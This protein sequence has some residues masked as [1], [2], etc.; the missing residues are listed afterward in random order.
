MT[1]IRRV[2][3]SISG[4]YKELYPQ[5]EELLERPI[6]ATF[7][8]AGSSSIEEGITCLSEILYNQDQ[9]SPRMWKFFFTIIDLYVNDKGLL[10]EFIF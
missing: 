3:E 2:L 7:T 4:Q 1:A 9:I 6:E 10:D 8:E 5:I